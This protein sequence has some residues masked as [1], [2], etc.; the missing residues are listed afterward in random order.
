LL[1]LF[2]FRER[3]RSIR[4]RHAEAE[5][6]R[7][8]AEKQARGYAEAETRARQEAERRSAQERT[9]R[10]TWEAERRAE[11]ARQAQEEERKRQDQR[12]RRR[13]LED[14]QKLA[15]FEFEAL[16][17]QLFRGDG[18]QV[19]PCGGSGDEGI[20]L[21]LRINQSKDVVQ[22][23]RWKSDLGSAVVREFYGSLM[24]AGARQ[25][26]IITT[27]SFSASARSF[28]VGKPIL[29]IDGHT[30]VAWIGGQ[31]PKARKAGSA[32]R[33]SQS[34]EDQIDPYEI[35]GISRAASEAEIRAAYKR[36]SLRYHPD[37]VSH[38][39]EEFKVIAEEKMRLINR[40][41]EMLSG[42]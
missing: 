25:G 36:E 40:A 34:K 16:I 7:V 24:H 18:Y 37:R 23:K 12:N 32:G 9:R 10:E 38:L 5:H 3:L 21:I 8:E 20:D 19:I 1:C 15:G 13:S 26:F 39:G 30:L 27:A 31:R 42:S 11:A 28:A 17:E 6:R 4:K 29:L 2:G 35:L 14:L 22:C 33:G 41:F